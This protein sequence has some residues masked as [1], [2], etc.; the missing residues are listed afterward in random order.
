MHNKAWNSSVRIRARRFNFLKIG[1]IAIVSTVAFLICVS[2]VHPGVDAGTSLAGLPA[3]GALG[4]LMFM[5]S[6][7]GGGGGSAD[8]KGP[9]DS[10]AAPDLT[11]DTLE[12]KNTSALGIIKS[13]FQAGKDLVSRL[14]TANNERDR[15]QQ[16]F[17]A[18]TRD[19]ENEKSE[20]GKTKN[21]LSEA[22]T[23]VAGLT[24]ERD[25]ANKNV[26]RLEKLCNLRGI[27]PKTVV[28]A[29]T[30]PA[31][32]SASGNIVEQYQNLRT[33]EKEGKVKPGSALAFYQKNSKA[34]HEWQNAH[35]SES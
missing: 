4:C 17:D 35:K 32:G 14:S 24:T 20:H 12:A 2:A 27:D 16:Q 25:N 30:D 7:S 13:L 21:T 28:P 22:N 8:N 6:N 26:E 31:G 23:K 5:D 18:V 1:A 10:E 3:M 15:L 34:I 19:F 11:G 29:S 33:Q 9:F